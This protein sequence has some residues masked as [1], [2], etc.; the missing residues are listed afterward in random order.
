LGVNFEAADELRMNDLSLFFR[1]QSDL[2]VLGIDRLVIE[3]KKKVT[4]KDN[5]GIYVHDSCS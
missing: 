5:Q 4:H 1:V 2:H 3:K